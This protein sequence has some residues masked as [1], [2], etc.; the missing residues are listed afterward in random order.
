MHLTLI[1]AFS[2]LRGTSL[3]SLERDATLSTGTNTELQ[4]RVFFFLVGL[5]GPCLPLRC[6]FWQFIS[7]FV[8]LLSTKHALHCFSFPCAMFQVMGPAEGVMERDGS[9]KAAG[10]DR[11]LGSLW[12]G[13][14]AT[15]GSRPAARSSGPARGRRTTPLAEVAARSGGEVIQ[16]HRSGLTGIRSLVY[17]LRNLSALIVVKKAD[18]HLEKMD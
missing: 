13:H 18:Q 16:G 9:S 8:H 14:E 11:V 6:P 15:G 7:C 17:G 12:S 5:F 4:L 3:S 1:D 2:S 10:L